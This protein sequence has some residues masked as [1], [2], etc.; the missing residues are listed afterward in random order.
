MYCEALWGK[1]VIWGHSL[2][3]LTSCFGGRVSWLTTYQI[4]F[5]HKWKHIFMYNI[6]SKAQL[7][8]S[9]CRQWF[10]KFIQFLLM[11]RVTQIQRFFKGSLVIFSTDVV[12]SSLCEQPFTSHRNI[13]HIS[14]LTLSEKF[15]VCIFYL[16]KLWQ[17]FK[18][19]WR[20]VPCSPWC[21]L[22]LK[23]PLVQIL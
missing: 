13:H 15:F 14:K 2:T 21:I 9:V 7:V 8:K 23:A 5:L 20:H 10:T 19:W 4:S 11:H 1:F 16:V 22:H 3:E 18:K 6:N 12:R 17:H